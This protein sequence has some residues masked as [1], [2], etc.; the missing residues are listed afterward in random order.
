MAYITLFATLVQDPTRSRLLWVRKTTNMTTFMCLKVR[1][2]DF[3]KCLY[4]KFYKR[5][6]G[7]WDQKE[8]CSNWIEEQYIHNEKSFC[9][10]F[11]I[12]STKERRELG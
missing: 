7:E 10:F 4:H 11:N 1:Y 3:P 6:G 2:D 8:L 12:L 9:P 5:R